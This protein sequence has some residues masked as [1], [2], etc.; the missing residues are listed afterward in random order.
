MDYGF[1]APTLSFPVAGTII[2][3]Q[4][5]LKTRTGLDRFCDALLQIHN[6][7]RELWGTILQKTMFCQMHH[8]QQQSLPDAWDRPY[9]REK[10]AYPLAYL[11]HVG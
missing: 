7:F 8:I 2:L 9:T 6:E 5:N 1:H 11:K 3:N 10:A 4:Q